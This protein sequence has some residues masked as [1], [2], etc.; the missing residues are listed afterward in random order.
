M[1]VNTDDVNQDRNS[2]D[3]ASASYESKRQTYAGAQHQSKNKMHVQQLI[4]A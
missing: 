1:S 3:R 2:Y 4:P